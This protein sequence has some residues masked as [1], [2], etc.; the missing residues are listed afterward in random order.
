MRINVITRDSIIEDIVVKYPEIIGPLAR[1]GLVCIS[2]GEP[3]WGTFGELAERK[4]ISN[5]SEIL[6]RINKKII[7]KKRF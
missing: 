1:Y 3:V 7:T 2:C 4:G 5:L 6:Q